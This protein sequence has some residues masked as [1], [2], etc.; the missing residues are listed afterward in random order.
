MKR[1]KSCRVQNTFGKTDQLECRCLLTNSFFKMVV[2]GDSTLAPRNFTHFDDSLFFTTGVSSKIMR[3]DHTVDGTEVFQ[4]YGASTT[5]IRDILLANDRMFWLYRDQVWVSD[6]TMSGTFDLTSWIENFRDEVT[7]VD[8]FIATGSH[9]YFQVQYNLNNNT[10]AELWVTNGTTSE[11]YPVVRESSVSNRTLSVGTLGNSL[12]FDVD[13]ETTGRELWITHGERNDARLLKDIN[14]EGDAFGT[15]SAHRSAFVSDG[16]KAYFPAAT[17]SHGMELWVTD[18]TAAGTQQVKDIRPGNNGSIYL[19]DAKRPMAVLNETVYFSAK[20]T[21]GGER[22]LWRSDGTSAGTYKLSPGNTERVEH[23]TSADSRI[24]FAAAPGNDDELWTSDGTAAGT[25]RVAEI[26]PGSRGA[27]LEDLVTYKD[28]VYF[29]A[30]NGTDGTEFW[31]GTPDHVE[32]FDIRAGSRSSDPRALTLI[33]DILY[34]AAN[35]GTGTGWDLWAFALE[36]RGIT[37]NAETIDEGQSRQAIVR[38][39]GGFSFQP[40]S[41]TL[42]TSDAS[43]AALSTTT[44]TIPAGRAESD[45]FGIIGVEDDLVDGTQ[46]VVITASAPQH[47]DGTL[48]LNV[49][50]KNEGV[51]TIADIEVS[52]S[53]GTAIISVSLDTPIDID[54][55]VDIRFTDETATFADYDNTPQ[56]VTFARGSTDAQKVIIPITNDDHIELQETFLAAMSSQTSAGDRTLNFVDTAII[57]IIDDDIA[58]F[59]ITEVGGTIVNESGTTDVFT[60]VLSAQPMADVAFSISSASV[61]EVTVDLTSLTFAPNNWNQAQTVTVT[62]VDDDFVD[63]DIASNV[64]IKVVDTESDDAFDSVA[65]QFVS[66]TTTDDEVAGFTIASTGGAIA[67]DESGTTETMTV[68]LDS[69]PIS[70]VVL[71]AESSDT[72]EVTVGPKTLTFTTDNWNT[73]QAVAVTGVDDDFVDGEIS[74]RVVIKIVDADSDDGFDSVV[75]QSL[76][77][78]TADDDVAGFTINETGPTTIVDESGTTDTFTIAL[79]ARPLNDVALTVESNDTGEVSVDQTTLTFT[80]DNWNEP[81]TVSLTGVNDFIIDGT[82]MTGVAVSVDYANSD[83]AFDGLLDEV[84]IVSTRDDDLAGFTLSRTTV[85]VSESGT[86][87]F[88]TVVLD[89]EPSGSVLIE[90]ANSDPGEVE[91]TPSQLIFTPTNWNHSQTIELTG[92]DDILAD[93]ERF[94]ELTLSIDVNNSDDDFSLVYSQ[95]IVVETS[96]NENA[97]FTL[98]KTTATVSE[99]GSS[100]SL[101]VV[102]DAAPVV[103][104]VLLVDNDDPSRVIVDQSRLTFTRVNWDTPQTITL[105]GVDDGFLINA[106]AMSIVT[107]SI[108]AANSDPAFAATEDRVVTVETTNNDIAGFA[109]DS[110]TVTISESG[111]TDEV[112]VVLVAEPPSAVVLIV[113]NDDATEVSVDKTRLTFSPANWDV[114]QVIALTGVDDSLIDGDVLT[115][116]TFSVDAAN[117]DRAFGSVGSQIVTATTASD[118]EPGFTVSTTEVT[119]SETGSLESI[120]VVLNAQ[121]VADVVLNILNSDAGEFHPDQ[122]FITFTPDNWN[123]AQTITVRG[124]DDE[125]VDGDQV[126]SLSLRVDPNLS[127]DNFDLLEPKTVTVITI[128]DEVAGFTVNKTMVIVSEAGTTDDFTVVLDA[129]PVGNVVLTIDNAD[130]TEVTIDQ[131]SMTF[132]SL[133]WNTPRTVTLTGVEDSEIDENAVTA[134]TISVDRSFSDIAFH[135]VNDQVVAVTTVNDDEELVSLDPDGDGTQAPLTDGIL[136]MRYLAG[137]TGDSLVAEAV[138]MEGIRTESEDITAWLSF[139]HDTFLDVDGNGI[140]GP[141]TD[142]IL[143]IRYLAGFRG[144]SLVRGVIDSTTNTATRTTSED[145]TEFLDQFAQQSRLI[146]PGPIPADSRSGAIDEK[147]AKNLINDS[148]QKDAS[149]SASFRTKYPG[150]SARPL[151]ESSLKGFDDLFASDLLRLV[152]DSRH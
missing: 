25:V 110:T 30:D 41:V 27:G 113:E 46:S 38:R 15:I 89:A 95:T 4:D 70:D 94:T 108:D 97:G 18:G 49:I 9:V 68:V 67:I 23:I 79:D 124:L 102:L 126:S 1:R 24:Y 129:A 35:D 130:P 152:L 116:I 114:S 80:S 6:G 87:E 135:G 120:S 151:A 45:V 96:D 141:L 63:G 57:K 122:E 2:E 78:T 40:V 56:G 144:D 29:S 82:T 10:S 127:D 125:I 61:D 72:G 93:G 109:L 13:R 22:E 106:D 59:E 112:S 16:E 39:T 52:E 66:V 36:D 131:N 26:R 86:T 91:V 119:V 136:F 33:G 11:T 14:P 98:E 123:T 20:D 105:T 146:M 143:L 103:D 81:Q 21:L 142:G 104:V 37:V 28:D 8:Q 128:D 53:A 145:V 117:S 74:S 50:D 60:V 48:A 133:N 99:S 85:L 83:N 43:E 121:P 3:S 62:G 140:S 12:L 134:L 65:D 132:T 47:N 55:D 101:T 17:K 58:G 92:V 76:T 32:Q 138:S 31:K 71:S 100:D 64:V 77:I 111:I 51:F 149:L 148:S 84:I 147:Q 75:D 54:I 150:P 137:F 42:T 19:E 90:I 7:V 88:V 115:S 44:V 5:G 73:A 69:R 118:D 139:H 34:F 107:I